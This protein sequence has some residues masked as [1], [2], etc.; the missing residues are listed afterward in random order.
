MP[1][2]WFPRVSL[3][4]RGPLVEGSAVSKD[5]SCAVPPFAFLSS[6]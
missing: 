6:P 2:G 1:Y 4:S 3:C 5:P